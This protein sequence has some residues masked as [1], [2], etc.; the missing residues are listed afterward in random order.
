MP[1]SA[2]MTFR[3]NLMVPAHAP[4][5]KPQHETFQLP[6]LLR[7][8]L[9]AFYGSRD[10]AVQKARLEPGRSSP[11]QLRGLRV[12]FVPG[13][14]DH[15]PDAV[16][17]QRVGEAAEHGLAVLTA[18]REQNYYCT[19]DVTLAGGGPGYFQPDWRREL[20][21]L[22]LRLY[23]DLKEQEA[24]ENIPDRLVFLGHSKGGLLLHGLAVFAKACQQ[25]SLPLLYQNFHSLEHVPVP[26]VES[27]ARYLEGSRFVAI[28]TPFDGLDETVLRFIKRIQFNRFFCGATQYFT[29]DFLEQHYEKTGVAPEEIIHGVIT[30]QPFRDGSG[31]TLDFLTR[32]AR[33]LVRPTRTVL[34]HGGSTVLEFGMILSR[35]DSGHDGMVAVSKRKFAHSLHLQGFNH[36]TQ[37][38]GKI[39]DDVISF[40]QEVA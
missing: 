19:P 36:G 26:V 23:V 3:Q 40:L 28:G 24:R 38:G 2:P 30:T 11:K 5:L 33:R 20:P 22:L 18:S 17:L 13:Y 32:S 25:S 37:V 6:A 21:T 34:Y 16:F 31:A 1:F 7:P 4:L 14:F 12:I 27:V 35:L 9:P 8:I 15:L 39:A 10:K 29:Q